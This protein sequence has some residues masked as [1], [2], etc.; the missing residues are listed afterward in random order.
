MNISLDDVFTPQGLQTTVEASIRANFA[1]KDIV[2]YAKEIADYLTKV[3]AQYQAQCDKRLYQHNRFSI[4]DVERFLD[5]LNAVSADWKTMTREQVLQAVHTEGY[6]LLCL[7]LRDEFRRAMEP[8]DYPKTTDFVERDGVVWLEMGGAYFETKYQSADEATAHTYLAPLD[9]LIDAERSM[10]LGFQKSPISIL[11]GYP[12]AGKTAMAE[13]TAKRLG[14]DVKRFSMYT[15]V[16]L[17]D[18]TGRIVRKGAGSY[19]MTAARDPKRDNRF[20]LDFLRLYENGGVFVMDEGAIGTQAMGVIAWLVHLAHSDSLEV[21]V[22]GEGLVSLAK[23]KNFKVV[24]S[25][26]PADVT[27]ARKDIPVEIDHTGQKV[28]VS[29][30][31]SDPDFLRLIDHYL[32]G[33]QIAHKQK[34]IDFHKR[35]IQF[36]KDTSARK[37]PEFPSQQAATNREL[38]RWVQMIELLMGQGSSEKDALFQGLMLNYLAQYGNMVA[39]NEAWGQVQAVFGNDL[40]A[41]KDK[42]LSDLDFDD[43]GRIGGIQIPK[44]RTNRHYVPQAGEFQNISGWKGRDGQPDQPGLASQMMELKNL[45]LSISTQQLG[46][47]SATMIR[48]EDGA[49]INVVKQMCHTLNYELH[50]LDGTP[51]TSSMHMKGSPLPVFEKLDERGIKK[52]A[53]SGKKNH[54]ALGFLSRYLVK[55]EGGTWDP[56]NHKVLALNMIDVIQEKVRTQFNDFFLTGEIDL[57]DDDGNLETYILPPTVHIV[58]IMP[59]QSPADFTSAFL[60]RFHSVGVSGVNAPEELKRLIQQKYPSVTDREAGWIREIVKAMYK[61]DQG[62]GFKYKYGFN[63]KDALFLAELIAREKEK[64]FA[65][66]VQREYEWEWVVKCALLLFGSGVDEAVKVGDRSDVTRFCEEVLLDGVFKNA[67][68]LDEEKL[69]ALNKELS[70]IDRKWHALEAAQIPAQEGAEQMFPNGIS[71]V[72]KKDGSLKVIT[73]GNEYTIPVKQM[74]GSLSKGLRFTKTAPDTIVLEVNLLDSVGGEPIAWGQGLDKNLALP[75]EEVGSGEFMHYVDAVNRIVGLYLRSWRGTVDAQG[76]ARLS[77]VVSAMGDTSAAKT[78]LAKN[79]ARV[80]GVPMFI[81]NSHEELRVS[82]CTVELRMNAQKGGFEIGFKEFLQRLGRVRE[83]P[84]K[85]EE[86]IPKEEDFKHLAGWDKSQKKILVIDEA[87][88]NADVLYALAPLFRGERQFSVEYAGKCFDVKVDDEVMVLLTLNPPEDYS[89]RSPIGK[90][91]LEDAVKVWMPNPD[92]FSDDDVFAILRSLH[93]RKIGLGTRMAREERPPSEEK[94][95]SEILQEKIPPYVIKPV[96]IQAQK[97]LETLTESA[98]QRARQEKEKRKRAGQPPEP[99]LQH[100]SVNYDKKAIRAKLNSILDYVAPEDEAKAEAA[101]EGCVRLFVQ[102]ILPEYF[103]ALSNKDGANLNDLVL[104]A[105]RQISEILEPEI[106]E[107]DAEASTIARHILAIQTEYRYARQDFDIINT[108]LL[109]LRAFFIHAGVRNFWVCKMSRPKSRP[110][111]WF[112][113]LYPNRIED[114][115]GI[116]E[117]G[118]KD[119]EAAVLIQPGNGLENSSKL[120]FSDREFP[121]VDLSKNTSLREVRWTTYH[122]LAHLKDQREQRVPVN[123]EMNAMLAP[124]MYAQDPMDYLKERLLPWLTR[125]RDIDCYYTQAVKGIFN[126]LAIRLTQ[127]NDLSETF[128]EISDEFEE[129]GIKA[130]MALIEKLNDRELNNIARWLYDHSEYLESGQKGAYL[131]PPGAK[132]GDPIVELS[133]GFDGQID[134]KVDDSQPPG[135]NVQID[136]EQEEG[137]DQVEEGGSEASKQ[138]T[139]EEEEEVPKPTPE[140]GGRAPKKEPEKEDGSDMYA[141]DGEVARASALETW[142]DQMAP[143]I[144]PLAD[145]FLAIWAGDPERHPRFDDSGER[146]DPQRDAQNLMDCFIRELVIPQDAELACGVTV[147]NSGSMGGVINQVREMV[148]FYLA[149]FH[150]SRASAK[151]NNHVDYSYSETGDRFEHKIDFATLCAEGDLIQCVESIKAKNG[152]IYGVQTLSEIIKMYENVPLKNKLHL[153]ISD[154]QDYD[155][156][157]LVAEY[158][159]KAHALGIDVIAIGVGE[160]GK[161]VKEFKKYIILPEKPTIEM[162]G[163]VLL[164]L[165]LLKVSAQGKMLDWGDLGPAIGLV[166]P[167]AAE[168]QA[169]AEG[170]QPPATL[171]PAYSAAAA[172]PMPFDAA[173]KKEELLESS[174]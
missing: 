61:R 69:A 20:I 4:H 151:G 93:D 154:G 123:I 28:W 146:I 139:E 67:A 16:D 137:K 153:L 113:H 94:A 149:A 102:E 48:T 15:D 30:Q 36:Q 86:D 98:R 114:R 107:P 97:E 83:R 150:M 39:L 80:L 6:S 9:R 129:A 66:H 136:I 70:A 101:N 43:A 72:R 120:G 22:E 35:M 95:T 135:T 167:E 81:L 74:E 82:D 17:T 26:N 24:I 156:A 157:A 104:E 32:D 142:L 112:I 100:M 105:A 173:R 147:D 169:A 134:T 57:E 92:L 124:L 140:K 34:M 90:V 84:D 128:T 158:A 68:G 170:E 56:E 130:A 126:G 79:L 47:P 161:N 117:P 65:N 55:K 14:W 75:P 89:G 77:K 116:D 23:N 60:N 166:L 45:M 64:D 155:D 29:D 164:R 88:C 168:G 143:Q 2:P 119:G 110:G 18:F 37:R 59:T 133:R 127:L 121:V 44:S 160:H 73:P 5:R 76:F 148:K 54:Y 3:N 171:A 78:T 125:V 108:N 71:I 122:E 8:A 162:L 131:I 19:A 13:D 40:D 42:W 25:Q 99:T 53:E 165:S 111:R 172:M 144:R 145:A 51:Q 118:W 46:K 27:S 109:D 38:I 152:G 7:G 138:K 31:F 132:S 12:G 1:R 62:R 174:L 11:E 85:G 21:V 49:D 33:K 103:L 41:L 52:Q 50:I 63:I 106:M 159:E 58:G 91:L 96:P 163:Q 10:L 141:Q 87:T 115:I